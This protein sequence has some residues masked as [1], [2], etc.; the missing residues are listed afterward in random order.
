METKAHERYIRSLAVNPANTHLVSGD[1]DGNVYLWDFSTLTKLQVIYL[2]TIKGFGITRLAFNPDGT[3]LA[4]GITYSLMSGKTII[5]DTNRWTIISEFESKEVFDLAWSPNGKYLAI[6]SGQIILIHLHNNTVF[7]TF[8]AHASW[9]HCVAF[10]PDNKQLMTGGDFYDPFVKLWDMETLAEMV[11]VPNPDDDGFDPNYVDFTQPSAFLYVSNDEVIIDDETGIIHWKISSNKLRRLYLHRIGYHQRAAVSSNGK[12]FAY[13]T[14]TGKE[15]IQ[16]WLQ[17]FKDEK[18][19]RPER[20]LGV[21]VQIRDLETEQDLHI[22]DG[23]GDSV[24]AMIFDPT[25]TKLITGDLGG[26]I[27]VWTINEL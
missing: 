12:L 8:N 9:Q 11:E 22:I 20:A 19:A 4:V 24:T 18:W 15:P 7:K 3:K 17:R 25:S 6:A 14:I 10:S 2:E 21:K 23:Y 27:K 13:E 1:I 16:D 5:Y 26:Y